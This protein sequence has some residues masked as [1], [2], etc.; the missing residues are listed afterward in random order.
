MNP[1]GIKTY[2]K[3]TI[4]AINALNHVVRI[5]KALTRAS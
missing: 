2:K 4:F 3:P 5:C 1:A